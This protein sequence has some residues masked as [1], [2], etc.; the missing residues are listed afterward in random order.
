VQP[1]SAHAAL[2]A[3]RPTLPRVRFVKRGQVVRQPSDKQWPRTW[4][5]RRGS[6]R[7]R[8]PWVL[9][10]VTSK[11]HHSV[12]AGVGGG[13][14]FHQRLDPAGCCRCQLAVLACARR[15]GRSPTSTLVQSAVSGL[16]STTTLPGVLP[17]R[18]AVAIPGSGSTARAG[19]RRLERRPVLVARARVPRPAADV[20]LTRRTLL[21][22][23]AWRIRRGGLRSGD[24]RTESKDDRT[25]SDPETFHCVTFF[26]VLGRVYLAPYPCGWGSKRNRF[27][28]TRLSGR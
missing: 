27:M 4:D 26:C 13:G 18:A 20:V 25:D 10:L 23:G 24:G 5:R 11:S 15:I 22:T 6:R 17:E 8:A 28:R 3:R 16:G 21:V 9:A 2:R 19:L 1:T 7:S 14:R 12:E